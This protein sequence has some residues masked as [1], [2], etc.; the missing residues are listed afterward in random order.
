M[1]YAKSIINGFLAQI[2][3]CGIFHVNAMAVFGVED[4]DDS[5]VRG[6]KI[7]HRSPSMVD[8]GLGKPG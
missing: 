5:V 8:L 6:Q 4:G 3:R 7:A 1:I 2:R